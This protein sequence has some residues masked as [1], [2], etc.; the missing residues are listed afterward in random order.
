MMQPVL[1][2]AF[3]AFKTLYVRKVDAP[4]CKQSAPRER[5]L[6]SSARHPPMTANKLALSHAATILHA[7]SKQPSQKNQR[8]IALLGTHERSQKPC[9]PLFKIVLSIGIDSKRRNHT[10]F[11]GQSPP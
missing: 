9:Q 2:A 5:A 8:Q 4:D 3:I 6:A 7:R 10:A 1:N 11:N